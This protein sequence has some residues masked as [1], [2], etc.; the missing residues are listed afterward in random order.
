MRT[1][2]IAPDGDRNS[3][4]VPAITVGNV[5]D[6]T[7]HS[8]MVKGEE[9]DAFIAATFQGDDERAMDIAESRS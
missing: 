2:V 8:P 1:P 7:A 4:D 3:N 5:Y 9:M 6:F